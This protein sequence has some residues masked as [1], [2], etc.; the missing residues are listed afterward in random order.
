MRHVTL[1]D[2]YD[3]TQS[4]ILSS[5]TQAIIRLLLM[6]HE[7]D[8]R[9][10]LNTAGY[11]T[12]YRGSPLGGVDQQLAL[13]QRYLAE[14]SVVF[15]PGLNEDLAATAIW[16]AQQAELRGEGKYDGV[17]SLW[18]GKGPGVD[19]SGDIFRHANHAGTS[20]H[21]GVLALM[22]D[23]HTCESSTSAHQSEFA[24][25]DAMMPVINP[26]GV[27]EIFDYGLYGWALS[28]FAGVWAG[29]KCVKDNIEQTASVDAGV[30]RVKILTPQ[31]FEMP[32]G[33]LNIRLADTALA[34]E[35]RLH[36]FKRPAVLAFTRTNNLDKL[37][38]KGGR[39]PKIGIITTGKSYLDVAEAL[40]LLGI[41]EQGASKLG[42]RL[43]KV[44]V[45]WPLE[46]EGIAEFADGLD[47][48]IVVEEKR[49]LIETQ[50]K[51]QLYG[52]RGAP[53]IVGKR[54]ER[55]AMLFAAHGS[56]EP[57][58][59]AIALAKRILAGRD[60]P[61]LKDRLSKL[62]QARSHAHNAPH[63][64][65]R[66][67]Y[68]CAGCPHNSSTVVPE[69]AR[70]YAGIGCHYMVQWMDRETEGFT[71]M[72]GEGANWIG[73]APFSTR[74][75]IFQNIGDGTYIHSGVL[76][77]RAAIAAGTTMTF[78]ILYNDAVAMTGGQRLD[79]GLTVP[80]L[81][82]QMAAEGAGRIAVVS[83]EPDKYPSGSAFPL[84]TDIR[85]R[86]DLDEVQRE[87][88]KESGVSVLIYDQT[89]AAEKRRRRKRGLYPDPPKRAFIN[90]AVCE[91]CGDCGLKSNCVAIVPAETEFGRKR[92]IDQS[93]CNKDFSCVEGFCPSFVTVHGGELRKGVERR[94][95]AGVAAP[96]AAE[97]PDPAL[98]AISQTFSMVVTGVGGTGVVT[99]GALLAMAAHIEEKGVGVIDMSGLAQKGGEVAVHL[100]IGKSPEDINA[101]R[102]SVAGSDLILGCDL[103][104]AG[105]EKVLSTVREGVTT[106]VANSYEMMTGDF[107][108]S[109]DLVVPAEAL[110]LALE[111]R[112]GKGQTHFIDAHAYA[113]SLLGDAISANLFLL[114]YAYQLGHMPL[115]SDAIIEAIRLNGVAVEANLNAFAW[116]R[117]AAHDLA[118]VDTATRPVVTPLPDQRRPKTLDERID[119]RVAFLTNYQNAAYGER[120]RRKVEGIRASEHAK[121]PGSTALTEAVAENYFKLLAYK[122]EYEVA[123]LY[124][125]GGFRDRLAKTF[126]GNYTLEFHLAPPVL[127]RKDS[128]TGLPRKTAFGPWMMRLFS[129][130]AKLRGLRGTWADPF[131]RTAER[132][133]ER[134]LISDYDALLDEFDEQLGPETIALLIELASLPTTIRGFG[135]VK[136][137]SIRQADERRAELLTSLRTTSVAERHAA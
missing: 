13:A 77:I 22:G 125:D 16:G 36:L 136:D 134:R 18:F 28:R 45:V 30:D 56:L 72:G 27:Q 71:Q 108:R 85:S 115:G 39:A 58:Q 51:E 101:I 95:S 61:E 7:R 10:G 105:S 50:L 73:E 33:G 123:R 122:D 44:A 8:K 41:D 114:G 103:V 131:G 4:R 69:G 52:K 23:D 54:D 74:P 117:L 65:D 68:F 2:K 43:Y 100:R 47:Q 32:D 89:C 79:G 86:D 35:E 113:T 12:G 81:A 132:R 63:I 40:D 9:A 124:T 120:Y 38:Y 60:I 102:A 31:D 96:L 26:A 128:V 67:P 20:K 11:I 106:V 5:G 24:F 48:I 55:D 129:M 70:A 84:G 37:I 19:R 112:A 109:P 25:V 133:T 21:G 42:V 110:K 130:L 15:Q 135:H 80:Q 6:Q 53:G 3:L 66:V 92:A 121:V 62:E 14:R 99:V 98:P 46:P 57:V 87:L 17:F 49:S 111:A 107:T 82:E 64:A 137:R 118:A 91:G 29:L 116:G 90:E 88:A 94:Q 34:K 104:V 75:H 127:A 76:A 97:I 1:D 93:A 126:S 119:Y 83:D 59:I 78:K